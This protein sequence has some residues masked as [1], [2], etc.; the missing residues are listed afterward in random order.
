MWTP[1]AQWVRFSLLVLLVCSCAESLAIS[2][3]VSVPDHTQV[4]SEL[5][6]DLGFQ[7]WKRFL[8]KIEKFVKSRFSLLGQKGSLSMENRLPDIFQILPSAE[9]VIRSFNETGVMP[10]VPTEVLTISGYGNWTDEGWNVRFRGTVYKQPNISQLMLHALASLFLLGTPVTKL[11]A[12]NY[13][14]VVNMTRSVFV[15][16]QSHTKVTF[17]VTSNPPPNLDN[18][19]LQQSTPENQYLDIPEITNLE[20]DFDYFLPV[21]NI[22]GGLLP[23]DETNRTQRVSVFP[24]GTDTGNS[25]AYLV[26]PSGL[27]LISD[28]DD[29]LRVSTI[30][31]IK[32]GLFNLFGRPFY[33]WMNMPEIFANWSRSLPDLHF[34]YLTTSPE[35][36]TRPYVDF[37]YKT[38]PAGS[39]DMRIVNFTDIG[40]TLSIRRFLLD[41][42]FQTFPQRKFILIGDTTNLDIMEDYPQLAIRYPGQVQC[43]FLRN[44]SSTDRS[45]RVPYNTKWFK[46]LDQQTYMFFRVPNDLSGLDIG[47]GHCY[48]ETVP[49]NLTFGWQ[50][51]PFGTP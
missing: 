10:Q 24:Q 4:P 25:T 21:M 6:S 38:Y 34:H 14:H 22:S 12:A 15:L 37:I 27:T 41:K 19:D 26:P 2:T 46:S 11:A 18:G 43:I 13:A 33:P 47:N 23:G 16:K 44:T 32:N 17:H 7:D 9:E 48:N 42:V 28:I 20:G 36:L 39:F 29:V 8:G 50:G 49:Q 45:N 1:W 40:A 3:T 31:S 35:Q 5:V 51:L 30:Y